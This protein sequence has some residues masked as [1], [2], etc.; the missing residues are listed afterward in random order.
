LWILAFLWAKSQALSV[1]IVPAGRSRLRRQSAKFPGLC[2]LADEIYPYQ[3]TADVGF[4]KI[5]R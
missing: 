4:L 3:L 1:Q 5:R 2:N